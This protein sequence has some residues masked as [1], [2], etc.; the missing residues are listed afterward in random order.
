MN[1]FLSVLMFTVSCYDA[2]DI[3]E[4]IYNK[5]LYMYYHLFIYII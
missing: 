5:N 1:A 3:L 4:K 2:F